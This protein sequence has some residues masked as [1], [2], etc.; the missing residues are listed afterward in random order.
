[1]TAARQSL[2]EVAVQRHQV[3][4]LS[5]M[6]RGDAHLG[7]AVTST[8]ARTPI[9][10][11]QSPSERGDSRTVIGVQEKTFTIISKHHFAA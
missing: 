6:K 9:L 2:S 3:L 4:T 1:M 7:S 10:V 5:R 8:R 11:R